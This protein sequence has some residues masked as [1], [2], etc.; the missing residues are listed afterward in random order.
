MVSEKTKQEV[1][2]RDK[3]MCQGCR[4]MSDLERTPHH[5]LFKSE[6]FKNLAIKRHNNENIKTKICEES[7]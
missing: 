7:E 2:D 6:Y 5:C 3:G 1:Y 4:S